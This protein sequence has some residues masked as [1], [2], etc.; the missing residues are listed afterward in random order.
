MTCTKGRPVYI[1]IILVM[2]S[3]DSSQAKDEINGIIDAS[4]PKNTI[5]SKDSI[6]QKNRVVT[7]SS[8]LDTNVTAISISD[9]TSQ[10]FRQIDTEARRLDRLIENAE[11]MGKIFGALIIAFA[12]IISFFI[13]RSIGELKRELQGSVEAHVDRVLREETLNKKTFLQLIDSL[14]DA[15]IKWEAIKSTI[16]DIERFN[17]ITEGLEGD[18]QGA[19]K[20]VDEIVGRPTTTDEERRVALT[21]IRKIIQFGVKGW[22]DPNMLYNASSNASSL[23]FD[24]EA[25]L[26]ASLCAHWD[27]KP[28]HIA[29]RSRLEDMFGLRYNLKGEV[30]ARE[31][32]LATTIRA[33]A[34]NNL[35]ALVKKPLSFNCELIYSDA[36]SIAIRN[37]ESGYLDQLYTTMT[38]NKG[39]HYT[40]YAFVIIAVLTVMRGGDNWRTFYNEAVSSA[41]AI[42]HKESPMSTWYNHSVKDLI[43]ISKP[44]GDESTIIEKLNAIGI[45]LPK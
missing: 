44:I 26:L 31:D 24:H 14:K 11:T 30:L 33:D 34:W 6:A 1:A 43:K 7:S 16:K 3:F 4:P 25:L 22:V 35:L 15:E 9:L 12:A 23:D 5:Q 41:I 21:Y 45:K 42:L 27:P 38:D 13:T 32:V 29:R 39:E 40:S 19:Y 36:Q 37:R 20:A 18:A 17:Q 2:I 8:Q 10:A 28:S